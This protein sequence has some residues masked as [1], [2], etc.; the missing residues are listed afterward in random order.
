MIEE[1]Y[2]LSPIGKRIA[3]KI[4][5]SEN[6]ESLEQFM[7]LFRQISDLVYHS[8]L[9]L[10]NEFKK[11]DCLDCLETVK[12]TR[13]DKIL[14]NFLEKSTFK[15]MSMHEPLSYNI[16]EYRDFY[17]SLKKVTVPEILTPPKGGNV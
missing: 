8:Y 6:S 17:S 7:K 11:E 14:H 5:Q 9:E 4:A 1:T 16:T 10:D 12:L 13:G 2:E 3:E 15:F